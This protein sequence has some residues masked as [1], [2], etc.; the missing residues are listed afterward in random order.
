MAVVTDLAPLRAERWD[1]EG[2]R[3]E[4]VESTTRMLVGIHAD[5]GTPLADRRVRQ[6]LNYGLDVERVVEEWLAG[7]GE[8]Y[9]SWVNPPGGNAALVPWPYDPDLARQLLAEAGY[10]NGLAVT[11]STPDGAYYQDAA[12]AGSIAEQWD[13]IGVQVALEVVEWRAYVERLLSDDPPSLYLL[14]MNSRGNAIQDVQNVS[15]AWRDNPGGWRDALY[16][17]R[18]QLVLRTL[19]PQARARSLDELQA[20]AYDQ[21]PWVWLWRPYRFYGVSED[22]DWTPRRDGLVQ[23][24]E[25][26]SN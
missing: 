6:A 4:T 12:I 25:A 10:A 17:Q 23:L 5:P 2:T 21:A 18:L 15:A 19:D 26:R 8:R 9:G 7:Y 22:L 11:L 16:E 1:V 3:L 24:Y 13:E 20:L 14:A